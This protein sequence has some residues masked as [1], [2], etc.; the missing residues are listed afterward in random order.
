VK[1]VLP[2]ANPHWQPGPERES[3][4]HRG[5]LPGRGELAPEGTS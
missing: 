1:T 3:K 2:Q 4:V 5:E